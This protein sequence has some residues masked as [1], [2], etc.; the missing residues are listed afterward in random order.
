MCLQF[1]WLDYFDHLQYIYGPNQWVCGKCKVVIFFYYPCKTICE[2]NTNYTKNTNLC[3]IK[4]RT[5][6]FNMNKTNMKIPCNPMQMSKIKIKISW[7]LNFLINFL[8]GTPSKIQKTP[9]T[10]K[11]RTNNINLK[12]KPKSKSIHQLNFTLYFIVIFTCPCAWTS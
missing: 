7:P 10:T 9:I 5:V 11:R 2:K 4:R 1:L 6:G 12:S 8:N 3:L